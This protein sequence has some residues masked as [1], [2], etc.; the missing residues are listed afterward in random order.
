MDTTE[1]GAGHNPTPIEEKDKLVDIT[2][3]LKIKCEDVFPES[4]STEFIKEQIKENINDYIKHCDI[5]VE[6]IEV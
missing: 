6:N 4:W 3:E 2:I 5:E 1:L